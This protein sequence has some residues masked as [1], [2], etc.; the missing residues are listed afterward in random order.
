MYMMQNI[1]ITCVIAP[2]PTAYPS[3]KCGLSD[4]F[5]RDEA[6]ARSPLTN[7]YQW[8]VLGRLV[9]RLDGCQGREFDDYDALGICITLK[10]LDRTATHA[11][12]AAVGRNNGWHTLP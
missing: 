11:V 6:R 2:L 8:A 9:E 5:H 7:R 3:V 1:E 10:P 12:A 4:A